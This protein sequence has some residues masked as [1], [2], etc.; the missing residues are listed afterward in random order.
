VAGLVIGRWDV[1]RNY[2]DRF[3][4]SSATEY[5]F[6]LPVS[7][8]TEYFCPMDPGVVS[9]G[10]GRCGVCNMALV[11][12]KR[13]DAVMLPDG[14]IARM[15]LSPYRIQLAGIQ[16]APLAYL[17]LNR[18]CS[19]AGLVTRE[20]NKSATVIV[21]VAERRAP[22]IAEGQTAEVACAD[23]PGQEPVPGRI[24]SVKIGDDQGRGLAH[25]VVA[26]EPA[27]PTLRSGMVAV[28]KFRIAVALLDPFR[29]MPSNP[30][31]R[32]P[33]EPGR[34]YVCHD[35]PAKI[36][37]APGRCPVDGKRLMS[38]VLGELERLH[39]WCPMHPDVTAEK[40]GATCDQ[41]GGM[42]L[43]PK[44]AYFA[45][46]GRVPAIPQS[47]VVDTGARTVVFVESMPGMF[48][49]V[50]VVLGPR[51]GD[52]YPVVRGLE[53]GQEVAISGAF[54]LDAET[55]LNP[56]LAAGYFG[57]GR[58]NAKLPAQDRR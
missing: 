16:T 51:S 19:V 35:H 37:L 40:P 9:H 39:F 2:W 44:V 53:P 10:P 1:I 3:T 17:P 50:E 8:E 58:G 42:V 46:K 11:R 4:R 23:L 55:R 25:V 14:V 29:T 30:T 36:A 22:W 45:P 34:I 15:Q 49:A 7:S 47:A 54:L 18:E 31:P 6:K 12:R 38:Q 27:P 24:R 57:A 33:E 52:F 41:C 48:D 56:S 21:D 13:G 26:L 32:R 28:V 20:G 43:Q 5:D